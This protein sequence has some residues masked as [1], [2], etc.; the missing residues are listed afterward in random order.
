MDIHTHAH[1]HTNKYLSYI[2]LF[3][4]LFSGECLYAA[5]KHQAFV[6]T[7]KFHLRPSSS[8]K[9]NHK[10]NV[11]IIS[12]LTHI[13]LSLVIFIFFVV[14]LGDGAIVVTNFHR[15]R[16]DDAVFSDLAES[17]EQNRGF[18]Q[19]KCVDIRFVW[20]WFVVVVKKIDCN[21][22][23]VLMGDLLCPL[24]AYAPI[25]RAE[26]KKREASE[27]TCRV[28]EW[29]RREIGAKA[30][31]ARHPHPFVE[32]HPGR[33]SK[34][35]VEA[36]YDYRVFNGKTQPVWGWYISSLSSAKN[37]NKSEHKTVCI[38]PKRVRLNRAPWPLSNIEVLF[39]L[40]ST[41]DNCTMKNIPIKRLSCG[42][43]AAAGGWEPNSEILLRYI[44]QYINE[45]VALRSV[46]LFSTNSKNG[47][48]G[49]VV[50]S[51]C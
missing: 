27:Q 19:N 5:E 45:S 7:R 34:P 36:A 26:C 16:R 4:L 35:T 50:V 38:P 46:I 10:I 9:I 43:L 18:P 14:V 12:Y 49:F 6:R 47:Y 48:V 17:W 32:R 8:S 2:A 20:C 41:R 42:K 1:T 40:W 33:P 29:W 25:E 30:H 31:A 22:C 3:L 13:V 23:F 39:W 11:A 51:G 21:S 15:T 37:N 44:F 28:A 24:A